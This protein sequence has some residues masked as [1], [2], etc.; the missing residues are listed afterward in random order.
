VALPVAP[1]SV[2][3]QLGNAPV[4]HGIV[5]GPVEDVVWVP[6]CLPSTLMVWTLEEPLVPLAQSHPVGAADGVAVVGRGDRHLERG[7]RRRGLPAA[8]G[9]GAVVAEAVHR[10]TV[11][12]PGGAVAGATACAGP[13]A[14]GT[15][16]NRAGRAGRVV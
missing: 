4:A 1:V 3:V 15:A 16:R 5:T 9:D 6:T 7:R 11:S 10:I 13:A 12:W 14:G 8:D 2:W